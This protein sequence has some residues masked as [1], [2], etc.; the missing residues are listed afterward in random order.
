MTVKF[1]GL[2]MS[3][4]AERNAELHMQIA[5]LKHKVEALAIE[6]AQMKS[7]LMYW[8]EDSEPAK[9]PTEIA[10]NAGFMVGEEF[11]VQ[12]A[13]RMPNLTYRV[14]L[15]SQYKTDI[16]LVSGNIP[17]TPATD[18]VLAEIRAQGVDMFA[19]MYANES[20]KNGDEGWKSKASNSASDYAQ[21]LRK[22]TGR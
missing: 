4:L 15:S 10:H 9:S 7:N 16:E 17:E 18:A 13:A 5:E 22:E 6:N 3:Q 8:D 21:Q 20:I 14:A 1:E 12:V 11:E 19:E 2:T